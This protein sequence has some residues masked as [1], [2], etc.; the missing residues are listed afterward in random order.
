[1]EQ[2][3]APAINDHSDLV[4]LPVDKKNPHGLGN[5]PPEGHQATFCEGFE[6]PEPESTVPSEALVP[7]GRDE[8]LVA[9]KVLHLFFG[10]SELLRG[11]KEICHR[12]WSN[13]FDF[14]W[15]HRPAFLQEPQSL[16]FETG[17][18]GRPRFINRAG[19]K[20]LVNGF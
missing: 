7:V 2:V 17:H 1:M 9:V 19:S 6:K 4:I 10:E 13:V 12:C 15:P 18:G 14:L 5:A 3:G 20:K 11:F 16:P 8:R